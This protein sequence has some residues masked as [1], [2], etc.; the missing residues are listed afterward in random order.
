M[1]PKPTK[2]N[3]AKNST[4]PD[5]AAPPGPAKKGGPLS[6]GLGLFVS[7]VLLATAVYL[8]YRTLFADEPSAPT[9]VTFMCVETNKTFSHVLQKGEQWPV[10]SPYTNKK[11]GYPTEQCYWT[12][13]GKRKRTPTFVV[14]NS[15]LGKPGDTLC[16][17]CNRVVVGHNQPPPPNTKWADDPDTPPTT[18]TA[19]A[20]RHP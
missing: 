12:K 9:L 10:T 20:S 4:G 18:S 17:D 2:S 7:A 5:S 3:T 11:T 8:T 19:P 15:N 1:E 14:L 13:D 6:G 16:P